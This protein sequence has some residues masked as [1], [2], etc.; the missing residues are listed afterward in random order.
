M[1]LMLKASLFLLLLLPLS[2]R[3]EEPLFFL[4][5]LRDPVHTMAIVWLTSD[6]DTT[7]VIEWKEKESEAWKPRMGS[8]RSYKLGDQPLIIHS[9]EL[10]QLEGDKEY[11]FRISSKGETQSFKTAPEGLLEPVKFIVGGDAYHDDEE[12]LAKMLRTMAKQ[13]PLF[14]AVG[15]DI[16]YAFPAS[17]SKR[18][19]TV[20]WITFLKLWQKEMRTQTGRSIPIVPVIGNHDVLGGFGKSPLEARFFYEVFPL[21]DGKSFRAL[22]FNNYLSLILLDSGH[23]FSVQGLQRLWLE[24]ALK[25]RQDIPYIFAIYHVSSFPSFRPLCNKEAEEIR[26][27][28]APLFEEAKLTAAFEHHDHVLKRTHPIKAMKIDPQG[29]VYLGDGSMGLRKPRDPH[30]PTPWYIAEAKSAQAVWQTTLTVESA[31]FEALDAQG[32]R[33]DSLKVAR[34]KP[35]LPPPP[36]K[37]PFSPNRLRK[38]LP[39]VVNAP[40]K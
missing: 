33:L 12:S 37:S 23:T 15:G 32:C 38:Q 34:S 27:H 36:K 1:S 40:P 21:P 31:S 25:E 35:Y 16:A 11:E 14:A 10:T 6:Q 7:D 28:W 39:Q 19:E 30:Q 2:V 26:T 24:G 5:W 4:S 8:H 20:R 29:L 9:L 13:D 22:D 18:E 3:S 17:L